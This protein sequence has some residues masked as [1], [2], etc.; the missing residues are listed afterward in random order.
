MVENFFINL[1]QILANKINSNLDPILLILFIVKKLMIFNKT[2]LLDS[3]SI[4][5]SSFNFY[6]W[7]NF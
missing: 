5:F 6:D 2:A 1:I 4:L 7:K 3:K